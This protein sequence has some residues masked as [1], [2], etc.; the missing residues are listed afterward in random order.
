MKTLAKSQIQDLIPHR[1]PILLLDEIVDWQPNAW[2]EAIRHFP[3]NDPLFEGH[4]PG[5]PV[6]P[7]MLTIE[8]VAQAAAVLVSLSRGHTAQT[9]TYMFGGVNEA[10]FT[11]PIRPG[12]TLT[13][14]A[15]QQGEK[16]SLFRFRG[17][18]SVGDKQAAHCTFTAKLIL[19]K[20]QQ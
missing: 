7:G 9:A 10:K 16:L 18:A 15:E 2:I 6:L 5:N 11:A 12:D 4:F 19:N 3:E 14:R 1:A 20:P 17:T 8:A 13:L